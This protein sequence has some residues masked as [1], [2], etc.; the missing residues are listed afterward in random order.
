MAI[1]QA[2]V[3][4]TISIAIGMLPLIGVGVLLACDAVPRIFPPGAHDLLAALPLILIALALVAYRAIQRAPP[5]EWAK[6][7]IVALAFLFWAATLL[8]ADRERARLFND[9]AIAA[10]V[11]DALL[12]ITGWPPGSS[13][14][15]VAQSSRPEYS[16]THTDPLSGAAAERA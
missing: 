13:H 2:R 1:G 8:C 16:A 7:T 5:M 11:L 12:V 4:R 9:I 6:T 15:N 3:R 14:G 10:F